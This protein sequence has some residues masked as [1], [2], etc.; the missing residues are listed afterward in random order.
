[1]AHTTAGESD[2]A[3]EQEP[4]TAGSQTE[5]RIKAGSRERPHVSYWALPIL[6]LVDT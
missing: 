2:G 3:Q 4:F 5:T 6:D 1:M